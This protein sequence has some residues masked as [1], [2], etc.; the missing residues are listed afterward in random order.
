MATSIA[1][2]SIACFLI[3]RV[4][5]PSLLLILPTHSLLPIQYFFDYFHSLLA[6]SL[7]LPDSLSTA[8][9]IT[10]WSIARSIYPWSIPD[11]L[12]DHPSLQSFLSDPSL[13][14]PYLISW[15]IAC[16]RSIT[17]LTT[18]WSFNPSIAPSLVDYFLIDPS[19]ASWSINCI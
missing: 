7:M 17:T 19:I 5:H 11:K 12:H 6:F 15:S 9:F 10:S 1:P 3:H 14:D 16:C 13:L 2:W 4:Y 18:F 8:P